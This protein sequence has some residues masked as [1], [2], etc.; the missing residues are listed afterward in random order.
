MASS[1]MLRRVA[2]VRIDVSAELGTS[3]IRLTRIGELGTTLA[4]TINRRTL[5]RNT[6]LQLALFV[7]HF[8]GNL[9]LVQG[10]IGHNILEVT[11]LVLGLH[12]WFETL[13][14]SGYETCLYSEGIR[15]D[16]GACG[17]PWTWE[18]C[19]YFHI[20]FVARVL[21]KASLRFL[22][23]GF[24]LWFCGEAATSLRICDVFLFQ[25]QK[26]SY[27]QCGLST[28]ASREIET[29]GQNPKTQQSFKI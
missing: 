15:F 26:A 28:G 18:C 21:I 27:L 2:R 29:V 9:M 20:T 16:Y 5:R 3:F 12:Y 6:W 17:M 8:V 13:K 19:N 7:I 1:V 11:G 4:V 10:D 22:H 23:S 25:L 24:I 14:K